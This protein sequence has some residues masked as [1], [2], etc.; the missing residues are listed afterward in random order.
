MSV[1]YRILFPI[2]TFSCISPGTYLHFFWNHFIIKKDFYGPNKSEYDKGLVISMT[3]FRKIEDSKVETVHIIR[4]NHLNGAGRLFGGMLMQ[5]MDEVAGIVSF[6]HA[7]CNCTTA[8]V[9]NLRFIRGAY[10]NELVAIIGKVT[11]TGRTSLEVRVDSYVEDRNGMRRPI[12]RAF[13]TMVA[14]DEND[15]PRPVP[16]I[17]IITEEQ[18]AEW[19]GAIKRRAMREQRHT[20]GF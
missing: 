6:R 8:S 1:F 14:L 19:E 11:Y 9:D 7:Q 13:F 16:Q 3:E 4:P 15:R 17:E 5:W 12:N 20:E 10:Q 18:K 2:T